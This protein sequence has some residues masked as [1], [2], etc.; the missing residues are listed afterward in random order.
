M[1]FA[2]EADLDMTS[3]QLAYQCVQTA[4]IHIQNPSKYIPYCLIIK[5]MYLSAYNT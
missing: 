4:T 2:S 1:P 3:Q 5:K